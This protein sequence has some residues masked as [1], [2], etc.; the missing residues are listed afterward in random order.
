[1]SSMKN[2]FLSIFDDEHEEE[3][4]DYDINDYLARSWVE[5]FE[6]AERDYSLGKKTFVR[7]EFLPLRQTCILENNPYEQSESVKTIIPSDSIPVILS[8][9]I[10][11]SYD[12]GR[13]KRNPVGETPRPTAKILKA[14][15]GSGKTHHT[16]SEVIKSIKMGYTKT[17]LHFAPNHELCLEA[18]NKYRQLQNDYQMN[19]DIIHLAGK[20]HELSQCREKDIVEL[21]H[22]KNVPTH[23]ICQKI[24]E[25]NVL[26]KC[27]FF[28]TCRYQKTKKTLE[29]AVGGEKPIIVIAPVHLLRFPQTIHSEF[30][31]DVI[32]IDEAYHSYAVQIKKIKEEN[33][34]GLPWSEEFF[35][36]ECVRSKKT[37]Q[38]LDHC[39]SLTALLKYNFSEYGPNDREF[40]SPMDVILRYFKG[41]TDTATEVLRDIKIYRERERDFITGV[42]SRSF[43]KSATQRSLGA[44]TPCRETEIDLW[45]NLYLESVSQS[46]RFF[47]SGHSNLFENSKSGYVLSYRRMF[48]FN[49]PLLL[50][51]ASADEI[52]ANELLSDTHDVDF[53]EIGS[54]SHDNV[55]RIAIV[56]RSFS[57]TSLTA[58]KDEELIKSDK[59]KKRN[60]AQGVRKRRGVLKSILSEIS[61]R[62]QGR[63]ILIVSTKKVNRILTEEDPEILNE[64]RKSALSVETSWFFNLRGK[65]NYQDCDTIIVIGKP[66][67]QD[68]DVSAQAR[69]LSSKS[70]ALV[71]QNMNE[72]NLTAYTGD[73]EKGVHPVYIYKKDENIVREDNQSF[74][75]QRAEIRTRVYIN[76]KMRIIQRLNREEELLQAEGRLRAYRRQDEDLRAYY[77]TDAFPS[78]F[79]YDDIVDVRNF[80]AMVDADGNDCENTDPLIQIA[81]KNF[82]TLS[83]SA[84]RYKDVDF[85]VVQ[86]DRIFNEVRRVADPKCKYERL[87][88]LIVSPTA[89][90][91]AL[92][93]RNYFKV[94]KDEYSA[95][96]G[97]VAVEV[98]INGKRGGASVM[99]TLP[100]YE[101]EEFNMV[102][103]VMDH[104]NV[105]NSKIEVLED[106]TAQIIP[107]TREELTIDFKN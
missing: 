7:P 34:D 72:Q 83:A 107:W 64:L 21:Y 19:I 101:G 94:S 18:F 38:I 87:N 59:N 91:D 68:F 49:V 80:V 77:I 79:A 104:F 12:F 16:M 93:R 35:K 57:T 8:D 44:F 50:L 88:D 60:E 56:G 46:G 73:T 55:N 69:A 103:N 10:K 86:E 41:D 27:K 17:I 31:P 40:I 5:S 15:A 58:R 76:E 74:P 100:S 20:T 81:I 99:W 61:R 78:Q 92:K 62:E 26:V 51:D 65:N 102:Q 106:G 75:I 23:S 66:E 9:F 84:Y 52:I 90:S 54:N 36:K 4:T 25:N 98:R 42:N 95:P 33:L 3:R 11:K 6:K 105:Y 1:M 70:D 67:L 96:P 14:P 47:L 28:D 29:S 82:A 63:K 13:K 71:I 2:K 89:A 24:D 30:H 32:V 39:K 53:V 22:S 48:P 37:I 97:W 45:E 43:T 85:T